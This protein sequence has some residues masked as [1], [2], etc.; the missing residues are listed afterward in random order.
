MGEIK[1]RE[2]RKQAKTTLSKVTYTNRKKKDWYDTWP[3]Q[4]CAY[5]MGEIKIREFRK[6][7]DTTLGK[8]THSKTSKLQ[9][10]IVL[11]YSLIR[12]K[13]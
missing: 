10:L 2:F 13:E 7:A 6:Q 11:K 3:G 8:L 5:K 9:T 1:I 4:A 12:F